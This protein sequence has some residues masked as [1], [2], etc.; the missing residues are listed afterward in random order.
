MSISNTVQKAIRIAK[1]NLGDMVRIGQYLR[2]TSSQ[3]NV[4]TGDNSDVTETVNIQ[5]VPDKFSYIELESG[6][7]TEKDV[8]ITVF[9]DNNDLNFVM[10]ESITIDGQT[11]SIFK[12]FP[13]KIGSF[14]P[15]WSLV[16]RQ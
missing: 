8:K 13:T 16:L 10:D 15:V 1:V 12:A 11:Y 2:R 5:W 14:T 3:Y 7:Y 6:M 9:N 4:A